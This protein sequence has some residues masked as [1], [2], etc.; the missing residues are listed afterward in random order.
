MMKI[1]YISTYPPR[2]CGI[3]TFTQ[4]L[5][6]A[7][8]KSVEGDGSMYEGSVI[9]ISDD[10]GYHAHSKEVKMVLQQDEQ[11]DY[12]EA[13]DFINLSGLDLCVLEH[14][15][16]IFGGESGVYILPLLHRLEMPF[17]VTLH[18]VLDTPSYN[19]KIILKEVCNMASKVVVM[20]KKA[21][22]F[23]EE[24]Y[25]VPKEKIKLIPHGVPDMQFDTPESRKAFRFE[26]KKVLLTFGFV[27]RNK[28]IE[29]V[30]KSLPEV[31]K[32]HP[33]T[34]Y[35]ILGKTHPNVIKHAG[36]EYRN[37]LKLLVKNMDLQDHVLFL[38]ELIDEDDKV[39]HSL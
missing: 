16:G 3:G 13:A 22:K 17:I 38:N 18:T 31:I 21:V 34:I 6:Q 12:L 15:F 27:S 11:A 5:Q 23:L 30:I 28:G 9:A 25:Q 26:G 32:N 37:Y 2:E 7:I 33:N 19:E 39:S 1:G 29:T 4:N 14:E 20:S 8:K 24:I 36:E 35:I 10:E